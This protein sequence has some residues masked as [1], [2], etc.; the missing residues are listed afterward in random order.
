LIQVRSLQ[1]TGR[2]S[3]GAGVL[4]LA[5]SQIS[6][7]DP[8]SA[9]AHPHD[10]DHDHHHDHEHEHHDHEDDHGHGHHHHPPPEQLTRAFIIGIGLNVA[11]VLVEFFYGLLADSLALI[12]DAGHNLSDVLSLVLAWGAT[13][14][15]RR[16][17]TPRHTYGFRRGT[18]LSSLVSSVLLLVAMGAIA[19]EAVQRFAEPAPVEGSLMIG[20]AAIGVVINGITAWLFASGRHTDINIRA[21]FLHMAGDA[22]VSVGVVI[23]GIGV[24]T[25]GWLWLDPAISLAIVAVI[26]WGTWGILTES[27]DMTFDAVPRNVDPGKVRDY[28]RNLPGVT[29]IHDLHIWAM[30]TT[31]TALTAHLVIPSAHQDDHFLHDVAEELEH[32][33]RIA[34]ATLQVERGVGPECDQSC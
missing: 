7:I 11:F 30:S 8:M 29:G 19:W 20:V 18:I 25:L 1:D 26:V 32:R 17:T 28:L 4:V 31:E 14:L 16:D 22:A 33:F 21:A 5:E 15:A 23:G 2:A 34:H 3:L 9:T 10:D 24:L 27:L 13:R 12:A 6:T